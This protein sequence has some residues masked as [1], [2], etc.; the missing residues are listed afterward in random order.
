MGEVARPPDLV[1]DLLAGMDARLRGAEIHTGGRRWGPQDPW[2]N[3]GAAGQPA[4]TSPWYDPNWGGHKP[5]WYRDE[6]NWVHFSGV[7]QKTSAVVD[8]NSPIVTMPVGLR[9]PHALRWVQPMNKLVIM[10]AR[11][12][13]AYIYCGTDGVILLASPWGNPAIDQWISLEGMGYPLS[14]I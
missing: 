2:N 13:S 10:G 14:N 6:R 11:M 1:R 12:Q 5:R 8:V 4:L 9:P 7:V 3:F